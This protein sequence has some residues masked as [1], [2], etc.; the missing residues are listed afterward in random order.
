[1]NLSTF[2][3]GVF[4]GKF[5]DKAMSGTLQKG[6]ISGQKQ[7]LGLCTKSA[8]KVPKRYCHCPE[9]VWKNAGQFQ[10]IFRHHSQ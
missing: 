5:Q 2:W 3:R 6:T 7:C 1:M 10:G 8:E 9:N 4:S